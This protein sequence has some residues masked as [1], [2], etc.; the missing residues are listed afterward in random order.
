MMPELL[1]NG[2]YYIEVDLKIG[3]T[4]IIDCGKTEKEAIA[5]LYVL[6]NNTSKQR[7]IDIKGLFYFQNNKRHPLKYKFMVD[8]KQ[9][10]QGIRIQ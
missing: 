7:H 8:E 3:Q 2:R 9:N 10:I 5:K 1:I 6:T 4:M